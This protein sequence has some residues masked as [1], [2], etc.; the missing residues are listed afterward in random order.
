MML[1]FLVFFTDFRTVAGVNVS[2][3]KASSIT[4]GIQVGCLPSSIMGLTMEPKIIESGFF[5]CHL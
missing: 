5:T 4:V 1:F 2:L 3:S